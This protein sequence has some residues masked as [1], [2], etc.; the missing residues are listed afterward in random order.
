MVTPL[1]MQLVHDELVAT[2]KLMLSGTDCSVG[3]GVQPITQS[4][5]RVAKELGGDAM[6]L[7]PDE[8]GFSGKNYKWTPQR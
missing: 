3:A 5:L 4:F 6:D 7:D 1:T 2:R 8:G